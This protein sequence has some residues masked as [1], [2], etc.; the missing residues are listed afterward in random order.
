MAA[1][2]KRVRPLV[3]QLSAD[4]LELYVAAM[5]RFSCNAMVTQVVYMNIP[6]IG[7]IRVRSLST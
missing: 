2:S 3:A 5:A 4:R 1:A 6:L 7:N